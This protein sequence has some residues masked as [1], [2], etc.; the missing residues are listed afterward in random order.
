MWVQ[1][2]KFHPILIISKIFQLVL[3]ND[4]NDK[5]QLNRSEDATLSLS[6][7][8]FTWTVV[9]KEYD[10]RTIGGLASVTFNTTAFRGTPLPN[11]TNLS[12]KVVHIDLDTV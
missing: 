8:N 1:L 4:T 5:G 2:S 10:N 12:I 11:D 3:Y 6:M 9:D 7:S